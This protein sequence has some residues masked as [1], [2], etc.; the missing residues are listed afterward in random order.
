MK[1]LKLHTCL[2]GKS[3]AMQSSGYII[4]SSF[5]RPTMLMILAIYNDL[6]RGHPK[7]WFSK[8]IPPTMA[9]N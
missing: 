4:P 3:D 8:G 9:L 5:M 2:K 7:W 1:S 6:S